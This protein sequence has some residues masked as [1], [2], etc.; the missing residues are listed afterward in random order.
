MPPNILMITCDQLRKDTLGCYGDPVIQTPHIDALSNRGVRFE[1]TF[2][3]YPVCGPNR[4]SL[5]TGRYPSVNGLKHNGV[6]L[7]RLELTLMEVLRQRGYSTYGAGKMH[8]GPQWRWPEDGSPLK[9]PTPDLAVNSQPEE[10][11]LPLKALKFL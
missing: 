4:A 2:T 9:D 1:N 7:P 3:A 11:E 6:F 10:W 5:A 8:F